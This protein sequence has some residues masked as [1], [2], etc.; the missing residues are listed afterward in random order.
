MYADGQMTVEGGR[1]IYVGKESNYYVLWF[2]PEEIDVQLNPF[3]CNGHDVCRVECCSSV[4]F[5]IF[6]S[7]VYN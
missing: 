3:V 2:H 4:G 6:F 5:G 1:G 7:L